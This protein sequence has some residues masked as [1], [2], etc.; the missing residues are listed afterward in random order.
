[1]AAS[2]KSAPL[3]QVSSRQVYQNAYIAVYE[4]VVEDQQGKQRIYGYVRG[5]RTIGVVAIDDTK[6]VYLCRQYRYL[7][8]EMTWEIPR[9]FVGK[10][11]TP[12]TA[13]KRELAEEAGLTAR[14]W[15]FLGKI[16]LSVGL[17]DDEVHIY[18]AEGLRSR[19][20]PPDPLKEINK[21]RKFFFPTVLKLITDNTIKDGLTVASIHLFQRRIE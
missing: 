7:F 1:M 12:L 20:R 5:L 21:V 18:L 17:I 6:N 2:R 13:A 15:K 9:G 3:R 14:S 16:R 4:D 11:E 8:D 10:S 19:R